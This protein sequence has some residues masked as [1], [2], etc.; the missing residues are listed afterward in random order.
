VSVNPLQT[1]SELHAVTGFVDVGRDLY[2]APAALSL[3]AVLEE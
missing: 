2:L 1:F 3:D